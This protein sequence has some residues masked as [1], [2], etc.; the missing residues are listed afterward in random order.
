MSSYPST[1][2][3]RVTPTS[4][5]GRMPERDRGRLLALGCTASGVVGTVLLRQGE[6]PAQLA[7][8][9]TATAE[10]S[11]V[12]PDGHLVRLSSYGAGDVVGLPEACT[13][14]RALSTV[15]VASAGQVLDLSPSVLRS[16]IVTMPSV[17]EAVVRSLAT[18]VHEVENQWVDTAVTDTR[19]LLCRWILRFADA[20]GVPSPRGSVVTIRCSQSELASWAGL[21]RETVVKHLHVLRAEGL[22]MTGRMHLTVPDVERLRAE[23]DGA[24]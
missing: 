14:R 18:R 19:T 8:L 22:V 13:G 4:F 11:Y 5:L 9:L 6:R 7:V 3:P 16:L 17:T 15:R 24:R 20:T 12:S 23:A 21:S 10:A 1:S 2:T